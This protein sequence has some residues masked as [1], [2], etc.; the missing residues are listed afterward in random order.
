MTNFAGEHLRANA[1]GFEVTAIGDVVPPSRPQSVSSAGPGR[2]IAEGARAAR[3]TA[4][5]VGQ[6]VLAPGVLSAPTS[7]LFDALQF[8]TPEFRAE[9][10]LRESLSR[11]DIPGVGLE[12]NILGAEGIRR[13][14]TRPPGLAERLAA[15]VQGW[16][17]A[18]VVGPGFGSEL[19]ASRWRRLG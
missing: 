18:H 16:Q 7:T 12:G 10:V 11:T 19:F 9:G 5:A 4:L 6:R 13:L 1:S 8:G 14:R 15:A 17:R 3:D 2:P